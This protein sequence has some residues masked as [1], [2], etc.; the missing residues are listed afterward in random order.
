LLIPHPSRDAWRGSALP[1]SR[2]E[3]R[4]VLH[5]LMA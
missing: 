4:T 5:K 3:Q 2:K 1:K